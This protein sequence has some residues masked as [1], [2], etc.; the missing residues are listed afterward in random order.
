MIEIETLCSST[1]KIKKFRPFK[2]MSVENNGDINN[3]NLS[4][5]F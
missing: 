2:G 5:V 1:G 3:K 4:N